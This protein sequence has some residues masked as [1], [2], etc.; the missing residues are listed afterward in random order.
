[1]K[2]NPAPLLAYVLAIGPGTLLFPAGADAI[3]DNPGHTNVA[4]VFTPDYRSNKPA[5]DK[6]ENISTA[7]SLPEQGK[8]FFA[9][10]VCRQDTVSIAS[11]ER[12]PKGKPCVD[13]PHAQQHF[14][15]Q[16][17]RRIDT[18]D[19][20][21]GEF[22]GL[23]VDYRLSN[24][25]KLNGI[26]GYPAF[27]SRGKL[28]YNQQVFGVSVSADQ[29]GRAW[30]FNGY[31]I[32]RLENGQTN[33][34]S[35]GGV[36]HRLQSKRSLLTYLD[37]DLTDHSLGTLMATGAWRLP[38]KTTISATLDRRN[39]PIRGNQQKYL[40]Q[41]MKVT[42]GWNWILPTDR[43]AH[44]TVGG[45][46]DVSTLAVGLSH[47]LSQRIKLS[48][49][50]AV[51]DPVNESDAAPVTTAYPS[52]YL[53]HLQLAGKDLLMAGDR[54]RLDLR[55]R[56]TEADQISTA[57]FDTKL[58]INKSLNIMPKLRA[59]YRRT[60]LE[61]SSGWVA[62]PTV[63]IVY[64]QTRQSSFKVEAGGEWSSG[65]EAIADDTRSSYFVSLGYQAKF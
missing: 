51:L 5:A 3:P 37:Y 45:Y 52:E 58:A 13:A 2:R 62:S 21:L 1:M 4:T 29:T 48:G 26:A 54:N 28:N 64:R 22:G 20:I 18:S 59:D 23:R 60:V 39:R 61:G 8:P 19:Y 10:D 35:T 16:L 14:S 40:Q 12:S 34:K 63:K 17:G 9:S 49:D 32:E 7:K 24:R 41:S 43:L 47:P 53:Y 31:L 57:A 56:V 15:V 38:F 6:E 36:I 42:E 27:A 50:V 33:G 44:Y 65:M 55:Y 11:V 30:G 46:S 25:L